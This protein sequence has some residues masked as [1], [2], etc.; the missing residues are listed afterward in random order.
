MVKKW[1]DMQNTPFCQSKRR[2]P[3]SLNM[4]FAMYE[5]YRTKGHSQKTDFGD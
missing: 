4:P 2:K 3:I 5:K 1:T